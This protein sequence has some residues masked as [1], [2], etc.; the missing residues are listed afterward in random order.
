MVTQVDDA[1]HLFYWIL[2][3]TV[4]WAVGL[5]LLLAAIFQTKREPPINSSDDDPDDADFF[6]DDDDDRRDNGGMPGRRLVH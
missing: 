5:G 3:V 2:V 4:L 1:Q 6:D